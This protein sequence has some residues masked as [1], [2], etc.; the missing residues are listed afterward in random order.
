M[1]K[2][3]R[4]AIVA[5]VCV[6]GAGV[7]RAQSADT[8]LRLL[9]SQSGA[10]PNVMILF[11]TSGSMK[12]VVW[13]EDFD[14]TKFHDIGSPCNLDVL[15][16]ANSDN[17]CPGSG[18][19]NGRCPDNDNS[20][21]IFGDPIPGLEVGETVSCT[22]SAFTAGCGNMPAAFNC[23][24][25]GSRLYI[26][27]PDVDYANDIDPSDGSVI[28]E[29]N[30]T[31]YW[32][33]NYVHW[34]MKQL[35]ST[36]SMPANLPMENRKMA[37]K[38]VLK[39]LIK[40]LNP[41]RPDG[42]IDQ[43]IRF[44]LAR[45]H[46]QGSQPFEAS[47]GGYVV[48][49][50]ADGNTSALLTTLRS[51]TISTPGYARTPLSESLIDVARYFVGSYTDPEGRVGLGPYPVYNRNTTN[52]GTSG[53]I[54]GSPISP[55]VPCRQSFILIVTDGDPTDDANNHHGTAFSQT[56]GAD[57]DGD[58]NS[59]NAAD[60]NDTLDDVAA[61]L[62][63][64][65]LIDDATMPGVQNIV[66][67]TIGFSLASRLL[68]DTARNGDGQY[69]TASNAKALA[70][71]LQV[72][73]EDILLRSGSFT[74]A[75]VPS[76]QS[77]FGRGFYTAY[78]E[79]RPRGDLY[80][81]H[82]QAYRLSDTLEILGD[83]SQPAVNPATGDF[84]E[85]R[86]TYFWDTAETVAAQVADP[87]VGRTLY[88]SP[89]APTSSRLFSNANAD[90][91]AAA[92]GLTDLD[93]PTYASPSTGAPF[94]NAEQL[95]D[96]I[97]DYVRGVD[98][99]DDDGDTS[100]TDPRPFPFGDIFHSS[101]IVIGAP[102]LDLL[103][104]TGY[105]PV[106]DPSSH[107]ARYRTREKLIYAGANDG[108]LHAFHAGTYQI[109]DDPLTPNT[110]EAAYYDNG[111]GMERFGWVPRIVLRSLPNLKAPVSKPFFVDGP[112]SVSEAW[113][114]VS[115]TDTTKDSRE[116]TSVLI[117]GLRNGGRGY[118]ALDITNPAATAT[119]DHGEFPRFLWELDAPAEPIGNTWSQAVMTR[120]KLKN[121]YGTDLCGA[122]DGEG[123]PGAGLPGDCREEWVAIFGAG[124]LEQGDPSMPQFLT[125]PSDPAWSAAS[126]GIFMVSLTDGS[127]LARASFDPAD[128][129]LANM[130]FSFPSD[131]AV[132]DLD[133]DGFADVVYIGDTGGQLWKWDISAVGQRAA[134][135][136]VPLATW[137][138]GRLFQAP[139][140]SNGH[141]R[142]FF[143]APSAAY[144]QGDLVLG[145]GTGERTNLLYP[146]T[147][148]DRNHYYV[149]KDPTPVGTGAIPT[150]PFQL[151]DLTPITGLA[152]DP[153]ATDQGY[154]IE[155][156]ANE[157]FITDTLAFGGFFITASFVPDLNGSTPLCSARGDAALWIFSIA[158]GTGFFADPSTPPAMAR[159]LNAGA[160]MPASPAIAVSDGTA[161][162]M[163]QTSAPR[164][165]TVD[166][167]PDTEA[168]VQ[169]LFWQQQM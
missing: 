148:V 96:A 62:F 158:D 155:A 50:I 1:S 17:Q 153:D 144:W 53:T 118:L 149:I 159:R 66:T 141:Y 143:Y 12:H 13:H 167:P 89:V 76:S 100:R 26:D 127:V 38:R 165:K 126:K 39:N 114:P 68:Q 5:A 87:A 72:T 85:P 36:G 99:F 54:P 84:Y 110:T 160:G 2:L 146:S 41:T 19:S 119:M 157:K 79:P 138:A 45:M 152:N 71:Q 163:L 65:D 135:S 82:L 147:A 42:T 103:A 102:P 10:P 161:K 92:L 30:E 7:A 31:T 136:R 109:G 98:A 21:T 162:V 70:D 128:P 121:G 164:I 73:L 94:A 97:I 18:A 15:T 32:S 117:A 59:N 123:S 169:L 95:A 37:A 57:F 22:R 91:A 28:D 3:A 115:T 101:P 93:V 86:T 67:Y 29:P 64:R 83:D 48:Q 142:S 90:L 130:V 112:I 166:G 4:V 88:V 133:F 139:Q 131:P 137:P 44:G 56:F 9:A 8:D 151:T 69:F 113:L 63:R 120:V 33:S 40:Q 168:P 24:I 58:G 104:E 132:L 75:A 108:M 25:S 124:Y 60:A 43:Q 51:S 52:G 116:W 78:F 27:V 61:Y 55:A 23:R 11:D 140:A 35:A 156:G 106:T 129:E 77:A 111:T 14:P 150:T 74:A 6:A 34:F 125:N 46:T 145:I 105:G 20:D 49:P 134:N 16:R 107:L 80:R 122:N 81:G 47:N 154:Y